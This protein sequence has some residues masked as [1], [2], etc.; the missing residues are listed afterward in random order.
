MGC[1]LVLIV[2]IYM[3]ILLYIFP[4]EVVNC[5]S[6]GIITSS[7]LTNFNS[8]YILRICQISLE[9]CSIYD[10]CML[11][12]NRTFQRLWTQVGQ[13]LPNYIGFPRLVGECGGKNYHLVHP[14]AD[15]TSV[16]NGTIRS[17]FEYCGQKCSA[18]S[19]AYIPESLWPE[20]NF[21]T[22]FS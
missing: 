20:V 13:N 6:L 19:R 9:L 7:S 12:P 11:L 17:A 10:W 16:V 21:I 14:S 22:L 18:C 3:Y 5:K 2:C 8:Y 4:L 1:R 15:V